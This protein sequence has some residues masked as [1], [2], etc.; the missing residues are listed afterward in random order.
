MPGPSEDTFGFDITSPM[1][2]RHDEGSFGMVFVEKAQ[3]SWSQIINSYVY[4]WPQVATEYLNFKHNAKSLMLSDKCNWTTAKTTSLIFS[5]RHCFSREELFMSHHFPLIVSGVSYLRR[6]IAPVS[7]CWHDVYNAN[8]VYFHSG[9]SDL[10][11]CFYY[12]L[13]CVQATHKV[14]SLY[15]YSSYW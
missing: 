5:V 3:S 2:P 12:L 9:R 13:R 6:M 10:K 15:C 8:H 4:F 11:T 14:Y 7:T 1:L